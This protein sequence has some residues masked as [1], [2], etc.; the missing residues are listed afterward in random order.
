MHANLTGLEQ[1]LNAQPEDPL[2]NLLPS[3]Y[4]LP[5]YDG[6]SIANIPPTI[7]RLLA[8]DEG[9]AA[10]ALKPEIYAQ[11]GDDV[12]RVILL[13]LDGI[14]WRRLAQELAEDKAGFGALLKPLAASI[15]PLSSVAPSTTSVATTTLWGNGAA[16]AEHGM[17]GY[18]F[19]LPEQAVLANMLFWHPVH[20]GKSRSAELEHWEIRPETFLPTPS[21]A[22][23]L[24]RANIDT[25]AI[26][27][28]PFVRSPLSRMQARGAKFRAYFNA[29]DMWLKIQSWLLDTA[30][31]KAYSYVYYHDFDSL[32]HRDGPSAPFWGALWRELCFHLEN[33]L[34]GLTASARR[35]TALLITADHGHITSPLAKRQLF[36]DHPG[37][38]QSLSLASG[39]EARHIYLY[40]RPGH[41]E[42]IKHYFEQHL[43]DNFCL[44]E[45]EAALSAG[46]YGPAERI[47][48]EA[49]RRLGDFVLL[50]KGG[51]Y[52]WDKGNEAVLLGK[53]GGFEP[54]EMI[55]PFIALRLD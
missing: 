11:L 18:T 27:P 7:G 36:Q 1:S 48:P 25:T 42:A 24:A 28:A 51:N 53:H 21:I 15:A 20:Q 55:V 43:R 3:S 14:G 50:S 13:L 12:E 44:I 39:G 29:T 30:G 17:L 26:I 35:K 54:E 34:R 2:Y 8:V 16:P 33:F 47:H 38:L 10:P 40:A 46:L 52:F 41:S 5:R 23:V 22:H 49:L 37:L 32:S 9:W 4:V 45:T 6:R 31:K 19:L